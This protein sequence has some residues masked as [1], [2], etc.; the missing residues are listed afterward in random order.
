VAE[1]RGVHICAANVARLR[2]LV[3]QAE[4]LN[5]EAEALFNNPDW[6]FQDLQEIERR[7]LN[8]LPSLVG[9]I[10]G[11]FGFVRGDSG[12]GLDCPADPRDAAEPHSVLDLADE[13]VGL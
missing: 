4:A 13:G 3:N 7:R 6:R 1:V 11:S 10:R 9:S 2:E 12:I 5:Q 8:L